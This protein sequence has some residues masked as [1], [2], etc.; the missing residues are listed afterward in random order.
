M[1]YHHIID[2]RTGYPATDCISVTILATDAVT[3]DALATAV[4]VLGPDR[5][6]ALVENLPHIE[7][8]IVFEKKGKMEVTTSTGVCL[9]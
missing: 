7:A 3:A 4:F 2:P 5:G 9:K 8:V 1:Q 6:M